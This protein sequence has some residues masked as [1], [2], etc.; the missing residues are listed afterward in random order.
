[1]NGW[2]IEHDKKYP[3]WINKFLH[4]M[5]NSS[6]QTSKQYAYKLCKF[7]NYLEE[8][9]NID[10]SKATASHLNK[11]FTYMTYGTDHKIVSISEAKMSGFTLKGYFTVIKRFY[12]YLYNNNKTINIE[13]KLE[14]V[15]LNKNSYLYGQYWETQ[16]AKLVINNSLERGKD[17]IEYEKWYTE[18]QQDA[19]LSQLN[20]YRDKTIFSI[21]CD[22]LRIDEILSSLMNGY[23]DTKGFLDLYKSK[24]KQT[25][26]VNRTCVLSERS[27]KFLEEYLFNERSFVEE[28]LLNNGKIPPNQIFL[29]LRKR[30]DSF[31]LPVSYHNILEIIKK[32]AK[33][34]GFDPKKIRTHSGRSTKAGQLFRMQAKNPQ[35]L[36]DNQILEIMGW[37]NMSS[38]EPYKNRLDKETAIE[39][40]NTLNKAKENRCKNE[41]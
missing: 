35:L 17:P 19:I 15:S 12:E 28:E 4:Q 25:G 13:L 39:N 29:N 10:Y 11:F 31:G 5:N 8:Y 30:D 9:H 7:L 23:D 38:A 6:E 16:K 3:F 33:K 24:G 32:A 41:K 20:T 21:S 2:I 36:T 1:M 14:K 37:K 22:G 40:W 18:E 27:R 34:A 26:N